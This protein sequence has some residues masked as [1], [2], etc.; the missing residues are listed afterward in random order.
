MKRILFVCIFS[1]FFLSIDCFSQDIK[2]ADLA[3]SWYEQ[4]PYQLR[5]QIEDY[6]FEAKIPQVEGRVIALIMPH[7]GL[8]Y[9]GWV[10]AH[11]LKSVQDETIDTVV[12]VGFSHKL[13]YEGI[14]V[15]DMDGFATPLGTLYSDK[16][17]V[18]SLLLSDLK[19]FPDNKVF[20]S[21]NSVEMILP[22]IQAGIGDPKIVLIAMGNQSYKNAKILGDALY[23]LLRKENNYL[24]IASTDLSHYLPMVTAEGIDSY[25]TRDILKLKPKELFENSKRQNRMCGLGPVTAVMIAAKELGA[26]KGLMLSRA[27]SARTFEKNEKVVGYLSAAFI[28]SN[29]NKSKESEGMDELLNSQ[30]RK[31]L[32]EIARQTIILYLTKGEIFQPKT[33]DQVLKQVM[34]AFVTIHKNGQLRGCIGHIIAKEPLYLGVRDMAIAASTEDPRFPAMTAEELDDVDIEISVLS[35]LR[36]I[37]DPKEIV[38][39]RHGV[40][41]RDTYRSGVYLPQVATETGWSKEEFLNSLCAS[42]AGMNPDAWKK[43]K[44]D[45]YTFTAQVFSE[46]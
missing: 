33:N 40:I 4:K 32:L 21:E 38:M 28:K 18:N 10:G 19:F 34:G 31:E 41:V 17:L 9:S 23:R 45:I 20:E 27:N 11:A 42:K 35:P 25:T 24:I 44:C 3:G 43:G 6:I 37:D 15:F 36:K 5:L 26:D 30:Q 22:M 46:K 14:A 2:E 29:D 39:G 8:N 7:A 12:V 16:K 13:A 1:L